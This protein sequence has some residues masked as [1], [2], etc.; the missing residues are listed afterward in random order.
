MKADQRPFKGISE[1]TRSRGDF[2][3][4]TGIGNP[5]AHCRPTLPALLP[6]PA[7]RQKIR[8]SR[9]PPGRIIVQ[10]CLAQRSREEVMMMSLGYISR[11]FIVMVACTD[12]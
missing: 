2:N 4:A 1:V 10:T 8:A 9:W 12:R 6:E 7:A 3:D 5:Q 11:A